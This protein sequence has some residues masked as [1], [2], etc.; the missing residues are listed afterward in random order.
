MTSALRPLS[1]DL[2]NLPLASSLAAQFLS[3]PIGPHLND[4]EA[5]QIAAAVNEALNLISK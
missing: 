1:S 4:K 5:G 2:W 3:L